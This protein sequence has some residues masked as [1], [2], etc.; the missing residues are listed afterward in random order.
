MQEVIVI[1][2]WYWIGANKLRQ[3]SNNIVSFVEEKLETKEYCPC[4]YLTSMDSKKIKE[5]LESEGLQ[6]NNSLSRMRLD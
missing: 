1:N 5:I 6:E 3:M 4:F 2:K